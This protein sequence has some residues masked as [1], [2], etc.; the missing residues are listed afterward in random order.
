MAFALMGY[1][2]S[3]LAVRGKSPEAVQGELGFRPTGEREEIPEAD[4][5]GV[6]L[7][8]G[9]YLIVSNRS[10]QV[11]SD[12]AMQ[13]LSISGGELVTCFVEEHVMFSSATGWKDGRKCWSVIHNA[14]ERCDHLDTQGNLPSTFSSI[15]AQLKTKQQDADA[16]KR[17]VDFLFDVPVELARSLVGYR[18]D[19]DVPGLSG[20]VFGL[21]LGDVPGPSAPPKKPSL[22]KRLFGA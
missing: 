12:A 2:L 6:E 4:L 3:W 18:H 20:A 21:L 11:A 15:L 16:N 5:S 8:N 1:S 17:R 10:E 9:W 14:Q 19:K 22:L 7:P 13:R